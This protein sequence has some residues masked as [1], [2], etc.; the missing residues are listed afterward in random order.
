MVGCGCDIAPVN[1]FY[2]HRFFIFHQKRF[3]D[4]KIKLKRKCEGFTP[5]LYEFSGPFH[6]NKRVF[7]FL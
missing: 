4:I 2:I 1:F 7:A 6:I 3:S 5:L